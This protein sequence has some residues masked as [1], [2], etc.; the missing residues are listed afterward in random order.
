MKKV[1]LVL[2]GML[3]TLK[4]LFC[5]EVSEIKK[6][7]WSKERVLAAL[8]WKLSGWEMTRYNL[9]NNESSLLRG[10]DLDLAPD[11]KSYAICSWVDDDEY[12]A[13]I[14]VCDIVDDRAIKHWSIEA[15]RNRDPKISV[16]FSPDGKIL[17]VNHCHRVHFWDIETQTKVLIKDGWNK[18]V[19]DDVIETGDTHLFNVRQNKELTLPATILQRADAAFVATSHEHNLCAYVV[20]T[21]N[22]N[23]KSVSLHVAEK[24]GDMVKSFKF[25]EGFWPT[26]Y[27]WSPKGGYFYVESKKFVPEIPGPHSGTEPRNYIRNLEIYRSNNWDVVY[28]TEGVRGKNETPVVFSPDDSYFAITNTKHPDNLEFF[29]VRNKKEP[30]HFFTCEYQNQIAHAA[31]SPDNMILALASETK[32]SIERL[33]FIAPE[34]AVPNGAQLS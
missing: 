17:S 14:R 30:E 23:K 31:W 29:N 32:I 33:I 22:D 11:G 5:S 25:S 15:E 7:V 16:S 13:T 8:V 21:V 2:I 10:L 27:E 20:K 6:L 24:D 26:S 12:K 18:W 28:H 19:F 34:H 3:F 4:T 9:E 1:T